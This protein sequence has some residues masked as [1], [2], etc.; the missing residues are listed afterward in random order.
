MKHLAEIKSSVIPAQLTTL[1]PQD[2]AN[3][4]RRFIADKGAYT[5]NTCRDQLS[6]IRRWATWCSARGLTY[7]PI[8][9]ELAR[10]YFCPWR[11]AGFH[12]APSKSTTP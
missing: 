3:N 9:P 4:L 10:I 12:R 7:L 2:V 11:K 6:V 5:D 8:D 1:T